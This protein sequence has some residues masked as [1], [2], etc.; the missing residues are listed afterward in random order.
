MKIPIKHKLN[1]CQ[2][3]VS[4]HNI[5]TL[6]KLNKKYDEWVKMY[7][8]KEEARKKFVNPLIPNSIERERRQ[9]H[10]IKYK[11]GMEYKDKHK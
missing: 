4:S 7:E 2:C 3:G 10:S 1:N 11:I 9:K 5:M 8:Q 6:I